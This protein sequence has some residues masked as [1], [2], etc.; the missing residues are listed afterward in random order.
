MKLKST[1]HALLL[2][3]FSTVPLLSPAQKCGAVYADDDVVLAGI[4]QKF[5]RSTDGGT[6]FSLLKPAGEDN[7]EIR[8]ISKVNSTLVIGGINGS[9]VFRSTDKGATWTVANAGM[10]SFSGVVIATPSRSL[11]NGGRIFMGG[12]NFSRYSDD[13]G[14]SWK[15]LAGVSDNTSAICATAG[16]L[17]HSSIYGN[18]SYSSDNGNSWTATATKPYF[19]GISGRAFVQFG[20]TLVALSD[21]SAGAAIDRSYDYGTSWKPAGSLSLGL[22]MVEVGGILYAASNDG[23]MM[24][25]DHGINWSNA[26]SSFKYYAYGGKMC[27]HGD[28]IWVA[29]GDG[30]LKYN[31]T[32]G[33]CSATVPTGIS[34]ISLEQGISIYPNPAAASVTVNN[35]PTG[36]T[37]KLQNMTGAISWQKNHASTRETIATEALPAGMYLLT[38]QSEAGTG[39][40]KLFIT[41]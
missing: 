30:I 14:L 12:T 8:C 28:I 21:K 13:D 24:S 37:L 33:T 34:A 35:V 2:L 10:P 11:A 20:D 6:T 4:D 1:R 29:S 41:K 36:A 18:V 19:L 26:C 16:K 23:L 40:F 7:L 22:D 27:V 32:T 5:Y 17:W 3:A 31:T 39:T 38:I 15:N 9:R 25:S